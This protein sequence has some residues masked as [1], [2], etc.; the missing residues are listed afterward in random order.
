MKNFQEN[1]ESIL[2]HV[3]CAPCAGGCVERLLAGYRRVGFYFSN[4][5]LATAAEFELRGRYVERLAGMFDVPCYFDT[6]D[7]GSWLDR[8]AEFSGAPEGGERCRRCFQFSLGRTAA[9]A[10]ELGYARFATSLTVSPRKSSPLIF[11][12]GSAFPDFAEWNFKKESGYLRG[13]EIA[14]ANG[15]YLQKF[16]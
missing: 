6:Y 15:F 2:L 5:N 4:S 8:C 1:G 13:R 14:R 10:H 11:E 3:C 9:A 7:H 16:C 12:V